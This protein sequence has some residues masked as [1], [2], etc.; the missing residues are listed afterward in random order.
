MAPYT[1]SVVVEMA[2][3]YGPFNAAP[4]WTDVSA[5]V[6]SASITRGRGSEFDQFPAGSCQIVFKDETRRFD[7]LNTA[8]PYYG[9]LKPNV[10]V[11]IRGFINPTYY[12]RFY[13][14]VD[15]WEQ[16]FADSNNVSYVTVQATDGF[17]ILAQKHL[18]A[19]VY[20][21][22]VLDDAPHAYWQLG[23][24]GPVASDASGNK[25]DGEYGTT[26]FAD[27]AQDSLPPH[28]Q[29]RSTRFRPVGG[30]GLRVPNAELSGNTS[31]EMWAKLGNPYDA[32]ASNSVLFVDSYTALTAGYDVTWS[33][34]VVGVIG[35]SLRV[36]NGTR[37]LA[38]GV[39][40]TDYAPH[41]IVVLFAS[42]S[43]SSVYVDGVAAPLLLDQSTTGWNYAAGV[44]IGDIFG[45]G[46]FDGFISDL[47]F[48]SGHLTTT[49]IADH[50]AAGAS[51]WDGDSTGMRIGRVLDEIGWPAA[52]RDLDNGEMILGPAD[53]DGRNA[54]DYL[55]SIATAEQ[56]RLFMSADGK[57]TF[58][59]RDRFLTQS[60]ESTSQF[61]FTDDGGS[62]L[63]YLAGSLRFTLD[64]RFVYNEADVAR[65]GGVTQS[66]SD[67]T[68][69]TAYG[70]R[71]RSLSGLPLRHDRQARQI[72]DYIVWRY[73]DPQSRADGWKVNP[74]VK[75]STWGSVLS[76]AVGYRVT[77]EVTPV[78]TGSQIA[79]DMHIE[80]ISDEITPSRWDITFRGSPVDGSVYFEWGGT[81]A[82]EGWGNGVW[83]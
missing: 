83:R 63:G 73:K 77:L 67:A 52:L 56:G 13:G 75:S 39:T 3:G 2:F 65:E 68:S 55:Q 21:T 78:R 22:V 10:P 60:T 46:A 80:L 17:K 44:L 20:E 43:S 29:S 15:G 45:D 41:H 5:Y 54:L 61:T 36:F 64:D 9:N 30:Q 32:T 25:Y 51:P 8:G 6:M 72:A 82:T 18:P 38:F 76:L 70:P 37:L 53:L 49:Q 66:V 4:A 57:V 12:A 31:V 48:W 7:P 16:G 71:T 26:P 27:Q 50:Y 62:G 69:I 24:T 81:G 47:S 1:P 11:R 14:Y 33:R 79:K 59:Q 58:H 34:A 19:S 28:S 74:Q 23:E 42:G 35:E 40:L